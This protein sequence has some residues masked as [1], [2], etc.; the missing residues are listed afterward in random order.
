MTRKHK[1]SLLDRIRGWHYH[2]RKLY[3]GHE[4]VYLGTSQVK[5]RNYCGCVI[6]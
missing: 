5:I 3:I 6:Q 4:N 2:Y 1:L